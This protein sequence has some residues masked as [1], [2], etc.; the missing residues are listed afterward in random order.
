VEV[1]SSFSA[2]LTQFFVVSCIVPRTLFWFSLLLLL[3][4][5]IDLSS[6]EFRKRG[7][8][9]L[10]TALF[11]GFL[12]LTHYAD[13]ENHYMHEVQS[14]NQLLVHPVDWPNM[15]E[16]RESEAEVRR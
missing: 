14:A 11:F 4:S 3:A 7:F 2:S 15:T 12:T 9:I 16:S 10:A 5:I 8:A 1:T 13:R 6:R